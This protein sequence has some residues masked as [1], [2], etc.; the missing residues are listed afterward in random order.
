MAGPLSGYRILE[1][2][3]NISGPMGTMLLADQGA[4]VIKLETVSGDQGRVAGHNRTGVESMASF[5]LNTNRN[6][7]SVVLDL[8]SPTG[9]AAAQKIASQCDVIVQNF[10]P[11]VADRIGVGYDAIK[12]LRPD[13]IYVSIDGL[14]G[15]GVDAKRRVYDI[16]IQGMAGYAAV[17]SPRGS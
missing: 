1:M 17:Q 14:G 5:Y 6:K 10:R 4:D 11:G 15:E 9:L 12:A 3:T 7:R 8:K 13:I 2:A 16:V